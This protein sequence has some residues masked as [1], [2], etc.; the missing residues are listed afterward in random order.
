MNRFIR[1]QARMV[2]FAAILSG[3]GHSGCLVME[4][5]QPNLLSTE[6]EIKIGAQLADQVL[7]EETVLDNEAVQAYV[8]EMGQKLARYSPR[9]DV[10]YSFTVIDNPD[11]VN[12]YAL[13]GGHIYVYTGLLKAAA[14]EAEVASVLAHE[15]GHVAGHDHGEALTRQYGYE[16]LLSIASEFGLDVNQQHLQLANVLQGLRQMHFSREAERQADAM[17]LRLMYEAGYDPQ[18]SLTFMQKLMQSGGST[19]RILSLFSSHPP[20][21]ERLALLQSMINQYPRRPDSALFEDRYRAGVLKSL[22]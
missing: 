11:V 17:G 9:Q 21:D 20:T 10:S 6:Q 8:R 15:L 22:S 2:A 1:L 14:N 18:A 3:L 7:E 4:G 19:P 16:M 13:P 12:A 5:Q